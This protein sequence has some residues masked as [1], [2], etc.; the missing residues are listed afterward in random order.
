VYID[1]PRLETLASG[2][3][4]TREDYRL[5]LLKSNPIVSIFTVPSDQ[6]ELEAMEE[7]ENI[8]IA[9]LLQHINNAKNLQALRR[10][11]FDQGAGV[12]ERD[13]GKSSDAP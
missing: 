8:V 5:K 12:K 4:K 2:V 13:D 6:T 1:D 10:L 9:E 11:C 7:R 3:F